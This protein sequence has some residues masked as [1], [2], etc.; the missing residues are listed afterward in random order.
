METTFAFKDVKSFECSSP[1]ELDR[2]FFGEQSLLSA[3]SLEQLPTP[4]LFSNT[5]GDGR[6][7]ILASLCLS[8]DA[9]S[10]CGGFSP[11]DS[12]TQAVDNS[13]PTVPLQGKFSTP[14]VLVKKP[15]NATCFD[16]SYIDLTAS[17]ISWDVSLIK[18]E[19]NSPRFLM[20][21]STQEQTWSPKPQQ[22]SL[23][24]VSL[25]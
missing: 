18:S 8:L 16:Q 4:K 1:S 14:Q 11:H 24:E 20:E 9:F 19:S 13:N 3:L 21:T 17:Q 6:P 25:D 22:H 15:P 5:G 10:P 2:K 23:P 12:N 7:S